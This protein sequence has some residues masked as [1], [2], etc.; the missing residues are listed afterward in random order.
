MG[1]FEDIMAHSSRRPSGLAGVLEAARPLPLNIRKTTNSTLTSNMWELEL[2]PPRSIERLRGAIAGLSKRALEPNLFFEPEVVSAAWPRLSSLLAPA[3]SWMLCLWETT[4]TH[5]LLR[6][7]MPFRIARIGLPK[8]TVLEVLS[9]DYL[10]L[11]TPLVDREN[12]DEAFETLFRLLSDPHLR[13]PDLLNLTHQRKDG[14]VMACMVRAMKTLGLPHAVY[15]QTQRAALKVSDDPQNF[16]KNQLGNKRFRELNRQWRRL[17]DTGNLTFSITKTQNELFNAFEKFLTLELKSWKGRR[18]TAL[19]NQRQV[20]AFSRQIVADLAASGG[21]EIA[22]LTL[23]ERPI[24]A[25]ILLS[26]D[27]WVM[28]WKIAYSE[29]HRAFSPGMQL[30]F[31]TTKALIERK[32]FIMADSLA[33]ADHWMMNRV[34]PDKLTMGDVMVGLSSQAKPDLHKALR[35]VERRDTMKHRLK[36]WL[37]MDRRKKR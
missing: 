30:M 21:S 15:H 23:D 10:P 36:Q 34:W 9:N 33:V 16:L 32:D 13:L 5:R 1:V 28:P 18:G 26:R 3:G 27:G 35:A 8:Q 20:T 37:S 22:L 29:E 4:G 19:Y 6:L 2:L 31:H 14:A 12:P 11:G 24:A 7:F 25:L 17:A